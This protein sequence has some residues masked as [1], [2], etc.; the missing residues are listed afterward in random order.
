MWARYTQL[1]TLYPLATKSV[2]V[3]GLCVVGDAI[4]QAIAE[5]KLLQGK[6]SYDVPRT[7]RM[8]VFGFVI[9]GPLNH[10]WYGALERAVPGASLRANVVKTAADQLVFA[11]FILTAFFGSQELLAGK[12]VDAAVATVRGALWPSLQLN[13]CFWPAAQMINFRFVPPAQRV[14]FVSLCL[15]GWNAFLSYKFNQGKK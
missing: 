1:L 15:V 6:A 11:P 4:S 8:A 2:T 3:S 13:W 14:G 9:S 5:P 10:A 7:L 12:S